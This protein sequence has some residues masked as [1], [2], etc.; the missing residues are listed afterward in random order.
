HDVRDLVAAAVAGRA[1]HRAAAGPR[2]PGGDQPRRR[3][4]RAVAGARC[5]A[6]PAAGGRGA[7]LLRGPLRGRDGERARDQH[8]HGE[9]PGGQG[10]GGA[11]PGRRP[12]RHDGRWAVIENELRDLLTVR[13]A[14]V[15]DNPTRL[16]E[17]R[18]RVRTIRRRRSIGAVLALVLLAIAGAVLTRLPGRPDALP[19]ADRNVPAPPYFRGEVPKVPG[20]S[21]TAVR[22]ISGP[23]DYVLFASPPPP[24]RQLI[25]VRCP[26]PGS[27]VVRN[28]DGATK[29]VPCDRR[30]ADHAEGATMLY[31]GEGDRL[32]A[33]SSE[34]NN[35]RLEPSAPGNWIVAVLDAPAP[36]ELPALASEPERPVVSGADH[37][38]GQA[39]F[40]FTV[41]KPPP[42]SDPP[43]GFSI[44]LECL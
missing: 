35:V 15:P 11:A 32:F 43:Y 28:T 2:R 17:V 40:T 8:R 10:A 7:A 23:G 41:P 12:R 37:P 34:V 21:F 18:S 29:T 14:S 3:P 31:P 16:A 33:Q 22:P 30:V 9:E 1:A 20:Y 36:D 38:K 5:A 26:R 27:L 13:A 44:N 24:V 39:S 4:G 42:N 6:A 25:V 19:P